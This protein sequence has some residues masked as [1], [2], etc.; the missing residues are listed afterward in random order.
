[1]LHLALSSLTNS[2]NSAQK[3]NF[4][5]ILKEFHNILLVHNLFKNNNATGMK[6]SSVFNLKSDLKITVA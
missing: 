3:Q 5:K 2:I 1:M 4:F 6:D